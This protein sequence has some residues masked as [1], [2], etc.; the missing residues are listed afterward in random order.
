[1][2]A[3]IMMAIISKKNIIITTMPRG[4]DARYRRKRR[5]KSGEKRKTS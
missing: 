1:M 2:V 3:M 5:R 4:M